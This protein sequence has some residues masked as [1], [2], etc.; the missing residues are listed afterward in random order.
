MS[1]S[2][3]N[4]PGQKEYILKASFSLPTIASKEREKFTHQPIS[5]QFE[6]PYFTVSGI[7]V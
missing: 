3:K 1:W 4:F 6:I 5:I 7:N 2:I